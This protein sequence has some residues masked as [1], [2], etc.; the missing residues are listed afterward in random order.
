MAIRLN[1]IVEGQTEEAFV[2]TVLRSHLAISCGLVPVT[3]R[4]KRAFLQGL[5]AE[6][7]NAVFNWTR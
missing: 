2:N 7:G 6:P 4:E 3:Y 1:F 5:A